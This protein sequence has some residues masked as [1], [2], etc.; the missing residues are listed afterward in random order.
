MGDGQWAMG[1]GQWAMGDGRWTMDNELVWLMCYFCFWL[2]V[3]LGC[4]T[5][6]G[7]GY[8]KLLDSYDV[9]LQTHIGVGGYLSW[10]KFESRAPNFKVA[11]PQG[12]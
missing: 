3:G 4:V 8:T 6:R 10:N 5:L 9:K 1:D 12:A 2:L 11:I 7:R